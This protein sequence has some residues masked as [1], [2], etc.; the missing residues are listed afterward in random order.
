MYRRNLVGRRLSQVRP[1]SDLQVVEEP[2]VATVIHPVGLDEVDQ[3]LGQRDLAFEDV[4]EVVEDI[5]APSHELRHHGADLRLRKFRF[6]LG[7]LNPSRQLAQ[8]FVFAA[9]V[10]PIAGQKLR[11]RRKEDVS[12]SL[13][14]HGKE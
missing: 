14:R 11:E 2:G 1:Q 4:V 10:A 3:A 9:N 13:I 12:R 6:D 8:I 5:L 7:L